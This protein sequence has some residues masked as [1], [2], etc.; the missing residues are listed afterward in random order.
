MSA[1]IFPCP[2]GWSSS[3]GLSDKRKPAQVITELKMPLPGFRSR[4]QLARADRIAD[5]ANA[6]LDDHQRDVDAGNLLQRIPSPNDSDADGMKFSS[7]DSNP[8]LLIV[9]A[10]AGLP[11]SGLVLGRSDRRAPRPVRQWWAPADLR[12]RGFADGG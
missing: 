12:S 7:A 6:D 3:A 10:R 8:K 9:L 11:S 2:Y 1:S 4:R 5:N